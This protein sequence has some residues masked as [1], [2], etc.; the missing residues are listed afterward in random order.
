MLT[1]DLCKSRGTKVRNYPE[2]TVSGK[3]STV[4]NLKPFYVHVLIL[5]KLKAARLSYHNQQFDQPALKPKRVHQLLITNLT[6]KAS[7]YFDI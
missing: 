5:L 7:T 6:S 2:K 3:G 1:I 4:L